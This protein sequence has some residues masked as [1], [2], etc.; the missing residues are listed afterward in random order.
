MGKCACKMARVEGCGVCL[1]SSLPLVNEKL[2]KLRI[3]PSGLCTDETFL[4]RIFM[5]LTGGFPT[6]DDFSNAQRQYARIV[7]LDATART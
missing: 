6:F 4:R 2:K 7:T 5:D 1:P 3:A